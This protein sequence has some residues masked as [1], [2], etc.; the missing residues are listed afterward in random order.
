MRWRGLELVCLEDAT[1]EPPLKGLEKFGSESATALK[2][3]PLA[4]QRANYLTPPNWQDGKSKML[5][6]V[7]EEASFA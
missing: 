3:T 4:Y 5:P 7:E 6:N 2:S 1:A